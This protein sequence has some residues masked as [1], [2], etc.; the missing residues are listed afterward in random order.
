METENVKKQGASGSAAPAD[1]PPSADASPVADKAPSVG[2]AK[3]ATG[4]QL[5]V[6]V[7]VLSLATKMFLLPIYLIQ[8]TGRDGYL[9]LTACIALDLIS[10]GLMLCAMWVSRDADFFTLLE[11]V[12]GKPCAKIV[13]ALVAAFLFF[14]LNIATAETVTFY[15][16]NVFAEFDVA[17]M[18]IVLLVFLLLVARHTL[19]ALCRLNELVAPLIAVG[20]IVLGVIVVMTGFDR[21]NIF[22]V[23]ETPL[24]V[25]NAL[26]RHASWVGDFTPLIMF[27]GRTQV[28]KRTMPIAAASGLIGAGAPVFF[29][30]VLCSAFGNI[31]MYVDS[32]TNIANILQFSIGSVYGRIDLFSS[33][34]WSVAAFVETA[35]TFYALTRCVEY[36]IGKPAHFAVG[37]GACVA[38]YFVQVFAMTDPT[39]FSAV[40]SNPVASIATMVLTLAIPA[41]AIVCG[42]IKKIGM[43]KP[44]RGIEK[45]GGD[46]NE[47]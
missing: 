31:P 17:L 13:V 5:V 6:V 9:V 42:A 3:Q 43:S 39:V 18:I 26:V 37:L 36:V 45:E 47:D 14:K 11:S 46:N 20:V 19:R 25:G 35:L 8:E 10:L 23:A 22:P 1:T 28:K 40:M 38:L 21:A 30:V 15:S 2:R 44:E 16:D 12:I 34:L 32:S 4:K 41:L 29:A 33:V 27:V 24:R 7:F